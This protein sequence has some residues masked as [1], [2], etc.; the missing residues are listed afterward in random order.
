MVL[1]DSKDQIW[2]PFIYLENVILGT[3]VLGETFNLKV[4]QTGPEQNSSI[5]DANE[6]IKFDGNDVLLTM[7]R[8]F[9]VNHPILPFKWDLHFFWLNLDF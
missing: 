6:T 3:A 9:Q 7:Q 4:L 2:K 5:K 8:R 1:D